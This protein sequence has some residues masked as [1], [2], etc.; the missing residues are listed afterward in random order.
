MV[1]EA[2]E[3]CYHIS[4]YIF[5]TPMIKSRRQNFLF[6][7]VRLAV[8]SSKVWIFRHNI[9]TVS[10]KLFRFG[11][12]SLLYMQYLFRF[13]QIKD[14]VFVFFPHSTLPYCDCTTY[15]SYIKNS[16]SNIHHTL[17]K[18]VAVDRHFYLT[19]TYCC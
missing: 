3:K 5:I 17:V 9:L 19:N 11:K 4:H 10:N 7:S 12:Y 1:S 2:S 18:F 8:L 6:I 13:F 16:F 15:I 14:P